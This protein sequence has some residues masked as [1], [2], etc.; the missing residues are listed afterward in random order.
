M[1]RGSRLGRPACRPRAVTS[2]LAASAL[3]ATFV[4]AA[5]GTGALVDPGKL[6]AQ[7]NRGDRQDTASLAG[8]VLNAVTDAPLVGARIAVLGAVGEARTDD[9]GYFLLTGLP[10]GRQL[11]QI[12]HLGRPTPPES[13]HL[14]ADLVTQVRIRIEVGVVELPGLEVAVRRSRPPSKLRSFYARMATEQGEF[15]TA[16][17]IRDRDPFETSDL[18]RTIPGLTV[19]RGDRGRPSVGIARGDRCEIDY[20]LDGLPFPGLDP[21]DIPPQDIDGIEMYRGTSEVPAIFRRSTTC[22]VIVIWTRDPSR[23]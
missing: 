11:V 2:A 6:A 17:E 19:R 20:W 12:H 18:L 5:I 4:T 13:I 9:S 21:N 8:I 10:A 1:R 14:V 3:A 22:A 16:N 23:P 15:I 7:N